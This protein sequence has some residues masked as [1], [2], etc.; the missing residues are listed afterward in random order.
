MT[1]KGYFG[2]IHRIRF[3]GATKKGYHKGAF[4]GKGKVKK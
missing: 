4:G 2:E 3:Y 1:R